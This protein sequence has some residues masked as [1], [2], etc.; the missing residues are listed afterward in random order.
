MTHTKTVG[1]RL[2]E[3]AAAS[4]EVGCYAYLSVTSDKS[5]C[6]LVMSV[7][8]KDPKFKCAPIRKKYWGNLEVTRCK[9]MA[10]L[11]AGYI[12]QHKVPSASSSGKLDFIVCEV[13]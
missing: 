12:P 4:L 11:P 9:K 3:V 7:S 13:L 6:F 5:C 1:E 8:K 2:F 10:I